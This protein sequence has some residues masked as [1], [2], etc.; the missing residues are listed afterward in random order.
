MYAP[1]EMATCSISFSPKQECTHVIIIQ[2]IFIALT[3]FLW[4]FEEFI[5]KIKNTAFSIG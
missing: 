2:N 3:L 4:K 1:N 5:V